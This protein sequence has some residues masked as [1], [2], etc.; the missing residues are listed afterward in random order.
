MYWNETVELGAVTEIEVNGIYKSTAIYREVY[1]NVLKLSRDEKSQ[2][3]SIGRAP[4]HKI[5]V[6]SIEYADES[7]V[8]FRGHTYDVSTTNDN[9]K[10]E[11][12]ELILIAPTGSDYSG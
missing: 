10:Y 5:E 7:K 12:V 3:A 6:R 8:R 11:T 4:S 2:G 1:C 9:Q